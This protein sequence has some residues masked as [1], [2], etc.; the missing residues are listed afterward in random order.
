MADRLRHYRY[1]QDSDSHLVTA[2]HYV[3]RSAAFKRPELAIHKKHQP[4]SRR[5]PSLAYPFP[6]DIERSRN[7]F[8]CSISMLPVEDEQV[9]LS[10]GSEL[11]WRKAEAE[12]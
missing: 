1:C 8:Q 7:H 11:F 4:P 5:S 12:K 6:S 10:R 9:S 2:M 3:P